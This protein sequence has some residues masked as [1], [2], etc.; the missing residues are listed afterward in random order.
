MWSEPKTFGV[1]RPGSGV[2]PETRRPSTMPTT[3]K[4]STVWMEARRYNEECLVL[5][6]ADIRRP[7]VDLRSVTVPLP[8]LARSVETQNPPELHSDSYFLATF[9]GCWLLAPVASVE[10]VPTAGQKPLHANSHI[11]RAVPHPLNESLFNGLAA[12]QEPP[13]AVLGC[14]FSL[15]NGCGRS[16]QREER[17]ETPESSALRLNRRNGCRAVLQ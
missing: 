14:I 7:K 17:T 12:L 6:R 13:R 15:S 9:A 1:R 4:A 5:H 2:D 3:T 8:A 11:G 10:R 16:A